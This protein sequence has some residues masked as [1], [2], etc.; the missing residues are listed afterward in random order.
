M[1]LISSPTS[2]YAQKVRVT[3]IEKGVYLDIENVAPLA[4]GSIDKI[5]NPLGRVPTLILENGDLLFDS[6]VVCNYLDSLSDQMP[7]NS[8]EVLTVQKNHALGDGIMGCAFSMVMEGNRTDTEPSKFWLDRWQTAIERSVKEIDQVTR[9]SPEAFDLGTIAMACA[10]NYL[11][12]RLPHITW[13]ST[14]PNLNDWH[15][16]QLNRDSFKSTTLG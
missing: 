4:E 11:A 12:F 10:L 8:G 16:K 7:L 14:Y 13:Q 2:P 6:V 5:K 15:Q 3:A 1:K 9:K